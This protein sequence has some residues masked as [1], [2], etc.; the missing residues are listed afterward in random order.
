G[1]VAAGY[2]RYPLATWD[3]ARFWAGFGFALVCTAAAVA[4]SSFKRTRLI[5]FGLLWFLIALL[6]TSLFPLA[7]VMNDHRTFLPYV[8]LVI[9]IAGVGALVSNRVSI[10][11]PSVKI[12]V[13]CLAASFLCATGYATFQR[14]KVWRTEETLWRDATVKSPHNGRALMNYGNTLMA[15]GDLSGALEYFH[16]AQAFVPFYPVLFVNLGVAEGAAGQ[17]QLA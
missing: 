13:A 5:G 1:A 16:R 15:K 2:A 12:A 10:L 11:R 8:G 3:D 14:N 6:P 7:E 4:L 9:V 17:A